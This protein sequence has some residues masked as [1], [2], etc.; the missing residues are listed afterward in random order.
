MEIDM[1]IV[2]AT[3]AVNIFQNS[4]DDVSM[5]PFIGFTIVMLG[6]TIM[7]IAA[8]W[9]LF[10][11]AGEAGWKSL[12]PVYNV[13]IWLK[14]VGRP[15]WYVLGLLFPATAVFVWAVLAFGTARSFGRGILFALGTTFLPFIFLPI[16]GF[17]ESE[18]IGGMGPSY[19]RGPQ[20]A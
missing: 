16:L 20:I 9:R 7:M 3:V 2:N 15:F 10:T 1:N 4:S 5:I 6:I 18:Y 11:K 14:I 12:I 13:I 17:G 19:R 8:I